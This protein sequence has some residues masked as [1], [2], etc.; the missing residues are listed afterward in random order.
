MCSHL[1]CPNGCSL[2]A[3][4]DDNRAPAITIIELNESDKVCHASAVIAIDPDT[5]PAQSLIEN[6]RELTIIETIPSV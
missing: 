3:L 6:R 5:I 2:S 4:R 1:P